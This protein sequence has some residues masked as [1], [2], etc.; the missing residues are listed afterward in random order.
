MCVNFPPPQPI[1][2]VLKQ[3]NLATSSL[4]FLTTKSDIQIGN[5][6]CGFGNTQTVHVANIIGSTRS[7]HEVGVLY[8]GEQLAPT[9]SRHPLIMR[10]CVFDYVH[11]SL[12]GKLPAESIHNTIYF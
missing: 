7:Q 12:L 3:L 1:S 6:S 9:T 4:H 2:G 11:L 5:L 8:T 10:M